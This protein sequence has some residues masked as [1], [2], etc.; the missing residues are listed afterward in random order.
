MVSIDIVKSSSEGQDL[1]KATYGGIE[2]SKGKDGKVSGDM[3]L[4]GLASNP[5]EDA[6]GEFL[7][8]SGFQIDTFM[9]SG[10]IN[11]NH[12]TNRDPLSVIGRPTIGT[13]VV[14]GKE[15]FYVAAKLYKGHP[16]AEQVYDLAKIMAENGDALAFSIEGSVI[17][18]D[19][20]N[21][22]IVTKAMI[23]GCAI[24]PNPKNAAS[25]ISIIKSLAE[26]GVEGM[27]ELC[28]S[29]VNYLDGLEKGMEA[30]AVQG[31]DLSVSETTGSALKTEALEGVTSGKKCK[32]KDGKK[33]CDCKKNSIKSGV[34]YTEKGQVLDVLKSLVPN[35]TEK[36]LDKLV[37][38]IFKSNKAEML[39]K[40]TDA[41]IEKAL[42][43]LDLVKGQD[44]EVLEATEEVAAEATEEVIEETIEETTEEATEE[45]AEVEETVVAEESTDEPTEEVVEEEIVD[46]NQLELDLDLSKATD[47]ELFQALQARGFDVE[48]ADEDTTEEVVEE[49]VT[50]EAPVEETP[51]VEEET[52][53]K[54]FGNAPSEGVTELLK[55]LMAT[56]TEELEKSFGGKIEALTTLAQGARDLNAEQAIEIDKLK[57]SLVKAGEVIEKIGTFSPQ[58]KSI[59]RDVD[60]VSVISKG[61]TTDSLTATEEP[62][63][64]VASNKGALA[65][66]L[67]NHFVKGNNGGDFTSAQRSAV[68]QIESAGVVTPLAETAFTEMNLKVKA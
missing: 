33:K 8:P 27:E 26:D 58:L 14:K 16:R 28:K 9:K 15:E 4:T 22:K 44:A 30:G 32:C 67:V 13:K 10:L 43:T 49:E 65:N 18:R 5:V 52:I 64:S 35:A 34:E 41:D 20:S 19:P 54:G 59:T 7:M 6:D 68:S 12:Q 31:G 47:N 63:Y 42:E 25:N 61:E 53:E 24:T 11:W 50:E 48:V 57:K 62:T 17:E 36:G 21:P 38:F 46:P 29:Y 39:E 45:V 40:V 37:N 56:Q 66:K 51:V 60:S 1:F 3:V 2:I 23:T 55:G